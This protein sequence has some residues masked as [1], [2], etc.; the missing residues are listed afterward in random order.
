MNSLEHILHHLLHLSPMQQY[1]TYLYA[2]ELFSSL[3]IILHT[4]TYYTFSSYSLSVIAQLYDDYNAVRVCGG[5][6]KSKD[7]LHMLS[8]S[9]LVVKREESTFRVHVCKESFRI[10]QRA[11]E[12]KLSFHCTAGE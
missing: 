3:M 2:Y 8:I 10:T 1:Y 4:F 9:S 6:K 7:Y 5:I 11:S 12:K